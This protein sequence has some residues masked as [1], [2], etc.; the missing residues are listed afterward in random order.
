MRVGEAVVGEGAGGCGGAL[1]FLRRAGEERVQLE[2]AAREWEVLQ[3]LEDGARV[4]GGVTHRRTGAPRNLAAAVLIFRAAS[5]SA[6]T[7]TAPPPIRPPW[8]VAVN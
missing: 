5:G 6:R 4:R 7:R 3:A 2:E 8:T 1:G